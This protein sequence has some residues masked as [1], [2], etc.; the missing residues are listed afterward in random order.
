MSF[1]GHQKTVT[2]FY[3]P[4]GPAHQIN[5]PAPPARGTVCASPSTEDSTDG[6]MAPQWAGLA[7]GPAG[8]LAETLPSQ[9][10]V[11]LAGGTL[12]SSGREGAREG[13]S[14]LLPALL[15]FSFSFSS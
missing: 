10:L 9:G 12:G 2:P 7:R 4:Q 8:S 14:L 15:F 11:L 6:G 3:G 5:M 1:G 13:V